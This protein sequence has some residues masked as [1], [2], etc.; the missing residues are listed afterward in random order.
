MVNTT[1]LNKNFRFVFSPK[2]KGVY[3]SK[4]FYVGG[5]SLSLYISPSNAYIVQ[6]RCLSMKTDKHTLKFRKFGKID[7]YV[8]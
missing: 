3:K 7:I 1:F 2:I 8:K 6:K 4:R 5:G